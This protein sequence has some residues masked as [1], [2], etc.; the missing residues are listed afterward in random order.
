MSHLQLF[1][2]VSL[3]ALLHVVIKC[4]R[5][6]QGLLRHYFHR[7]SIVRTRPNTGFF[8]IKSTYAGLFPSVG[9]SA[10]AKIHARLASELIHH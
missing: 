5:L 9:M 10:L 2:S 7:P 6:D 4:C 3:D 8:D 1:L